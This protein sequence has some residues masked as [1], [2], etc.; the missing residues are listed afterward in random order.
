MQYILKSV[1]GGRIPYGPGSGFD[2]P[3]DAF[4]WNYGEEGE[5]PDWMEEI[6]EIVISPDETLSFLG[7]Q[8]RYNPGIPQKAHSGDYIVNKTTGVVVDD[9]EFFE[10]MYV[11]M[12]SEIQKVIDDLHKE[13]YKENS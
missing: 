9:K 3:Y 4:Q 7:H 12:T 5:W 1:A 13:A 11:P 10:K 8:K 2:Q 6:K